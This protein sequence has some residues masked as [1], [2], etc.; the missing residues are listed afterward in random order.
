MFVTKSSAGRIA[1]AVIAACALCLLVFSVNNH[2]DKAQ[3]GLANAMDQRV[4]VP[5]RTTELST[6]ADY[7]SSEGLQLVDMYQCMC[8]GTPG[9]ISGWI[10]WWLF[11]ALFGGVPTAVLVRKSRA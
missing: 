4:A 11:T 8:G 1:A 2:G 7:G 3:R 6:A 9:D 5:L 10:G